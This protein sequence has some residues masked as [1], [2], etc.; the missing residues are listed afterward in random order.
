M[1]IIKFLVEES[2][3]ILWYKEENEKRTT[4]LIDQ[5]FE[6]LSVIKTK[7]ETEDTLENCSNYG[8]LH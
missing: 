1:D 5:I 8:K 3:N 7:Y 2:G 6:Q 4:N